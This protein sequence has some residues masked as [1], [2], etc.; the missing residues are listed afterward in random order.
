MKQVKGQSETT[1]TLSP[2]DAFAGYEVFVWQIFGAGSKGPP[3]EHGS[4]VRQAYRDNVAMEQARGDNP[5]KFGVVSGSDSHVT[6]VPYRQDNFFGLHGTA[7]S[8]AGVTQRLL[9]PR[10]AAPFKRFSGVSSTVPV[11]ARL[12]RSVDGFE[13]PGPCVRPVPIHSFVC[14]V[15][16]RV[17]IEGRVRSSPAARRALR[18]G[19][20]C[21]VCPARIR[22]A[23]C[24]HTRPFSPDV[25]RIAA[26]LNFAAP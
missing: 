3:H 1:P 22:D 17:I 2:N 21:H 7:L 6:V 13:P 24:Q 9:S 5:Y 10:T 16:R 23:P 20:A 11:S 26:R 14:G 12:R 8:P 19:R 4:Y 15:S 25:H 18:G